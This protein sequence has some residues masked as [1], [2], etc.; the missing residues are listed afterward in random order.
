MQVVDRN[1]ADEV[2]GVHNLSGGMRFLVSLSLALGL[3]SMSSSRGIKVE[4]LHET[5]FGQ[6]FLQGEAGLRQWVGNRHRSPTL[7]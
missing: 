7:P 6:G 3:A 2:R 1:M 5:R 4:R